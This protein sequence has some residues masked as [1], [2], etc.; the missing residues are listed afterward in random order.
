[1]KKHTKTDNSLLHM[2]IEKLFIYT[3]QNFNNEIDLY[4]SKLS[5]PTKLEKKE[6]EML[7]S[8]LKFRSKLAEKYP[9]GIEKKRWKKD[10][11]ILRSNIDSDQNR[12]WENI[13]KAQNCLDSLKQYNITS[14]YIKQFEKRFEKFTDALIKEE[15][16]IR[17]K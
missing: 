1:M 5:K 9:D 7:T 6:E 10:L 4:K 8:Y 17:Y 13:I 12:N 15:S 11:D 2:I 16:N 3:C 14:K